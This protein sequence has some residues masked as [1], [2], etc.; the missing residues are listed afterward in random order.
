MYCGSMWIRPLEGGNGGNEKKYRKCWNVI[1]Q[2]NA[3]NAKCT[4][5]I[6]DEEM[7]KWVQEKKPTIK[8]HGILEAEPGKDTGKYRPRLDY[9]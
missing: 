7:I 6:T 8:G 4:N 5:K 9:I 3:I 1:L 2:K